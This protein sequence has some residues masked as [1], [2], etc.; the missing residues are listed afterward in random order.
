MQYLL[1]KYQGLKDQKTI[2]NFPKRKHKTQQ[3]AYK[4]MKIRWVSDT[5]LVILETIRKWN[6]QKK[7]ME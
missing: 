2:Q 1:V 3:I 5:L 7:K 4:G 6:S